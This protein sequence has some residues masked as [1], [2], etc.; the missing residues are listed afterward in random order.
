MPKSLPKWLGR[1]LMILVVLVLMGIFGFQVSLLHKRATQVYASSVP[2]SS[3]S[4]GRILPDIPLLLGAINLSMAMSATVR[5]F[6]FTKFCE[7]HA[8]F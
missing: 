8:R 3:F 1:Y 6:P 4:V 2:G 7:V 5:D